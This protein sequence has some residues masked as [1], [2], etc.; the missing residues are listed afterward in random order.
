[1]AADIGKG[2]KR[3]FKGIADCIL[4]IFESDGLLGL[5]RGFN[6]SVQGIII[7]RAT[8][9]GFYDTVK[10]MLPDPKSTPLYI[11]FIIAEVSSSLSIRRIKGIQDI[12]HG[13]WETVECILEYILSKKFRYTIQIL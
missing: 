3:E 9:F 6:V 1:L 12:L 5:Y 8:Y 10:G 13:N 11:N 2:E 7:Y 4:K